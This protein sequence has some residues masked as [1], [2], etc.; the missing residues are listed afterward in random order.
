MAREWFYKV[1]GWHECGPLTQRQLIQMVLQGQ[2]GRDTP[3]RK[4]SSGQWIVAE[5]VKG[6]SF[7][8]LNQL[9]PVAPSE[10]QERY[11]L[12]EKIAS[13]SY[14]TV[15]RG[16]D[17]QQGREVAIK[18]IHEQ[19][20]TD[21]AQLDRYWPDAQLLASFQHP[22]I[23]TIYDIVR[24]RG[25]LIMELMQGDLSKIAG[26]KQ[27]PLES[28]KTTLAHCLRALK[29]LHSHGIIHGDIK[30][31][32]MMIDCRKRV[33]ISDFGLARRV[34]NEHGSLIKG[35]TNY[36][37]PEVV[38][39]QFG[40]EGPASDLYSLGFAAFELMCGEHFE[41]LFPG[42]EAFGRDR[43]MAWMMWHTAPDRRLPEIS[44]VLADVP[45]D[46]ARTI[47]K[48]IAKPQSQRYK[49]ADEAISD[50]GIEAKPHKRKRPADVNT[51]AARVWGND[52]DD[53][54]IATSDARPGNLE[55]TN[56]DSALDY[57]PRV[58]DKK[59][60]LK[61]GGETIGPVSRAELLEMGREGR[62]TR[63]SSVSDDGFAW[64]PATILKWLPIEEHVDP[65]PRDPEPRPPDPRPPRPPDDWK[66]RLLMAFVC[67][68]FMLPAFGWTVG[69]IGVWVWVVVAIITGAA[70][71]AGFSEP[72]DE[73]D[74]TAAFGSLIFT[75]FVG[76]VLCLVLQG[77]A[78]M[79]ADVRGAPGFGRARIWVLIFK[80]IGMAYNRAHPLP[81]GNPEGLSFIGTAL[82]SVV[83][84]GLCEE[85]VK[86]I[87]VWFLVSQN[88]I[89]TRRGAFFIGAMS[90]LGFGVAESVLYSYKLLL[91][92]GAP[93]SIY[94]MR[95]FGCAF[96]HA[97][98]TLLASSIM[99]SFRTEFVQTIKS[100]D[101]PFEASVGLA[102]LCA[103]ASAI[104]HGLYDAFLFHGLPGLA[105]ITDAAV[106]WGAATIERHASRAEI[107]APLTP[108]S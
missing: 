36:M 4:G 17:L 61:V 75:A 80:L 24:E 29:F 91:P 67:W 103:L 106:I 69:Q 28:L 93:L 70:V 78:A 86:L 39:D 2:I 31:S 45:E 94:I 38:S 13:G 57:T 76:V 25:W 22:N 89:K 16:R 7:P 65:D 85:I 27:M 60:Y 90:G 37:A 58:T 15:Y 48:L 20:L 83:S 50:L 51:Q 49:S 63:D 84:I 35:T 62:V 18:Q 52:S 26:R 5:N 88:M 54:P 34:N 30:P 55:L 33:K 14:A 82:T 8:E 43:Q 98:L 46:L 66:Q 68:P 108:N 47:Q 1:G 21:P 12:L 11:Q 92:M 44:R 95:F 40:E 59:W 32:N 10:P 53:R 97:A 72:E 102:A 19:F 107:S 23:V 81:D 74:I 104:P 41:E 79:A 64:Y 9:L 56:S 96:G 100:K 3:V 101:S 87:P 73:S 6:L 99:F 77:F 71:Y 42:I 105:G